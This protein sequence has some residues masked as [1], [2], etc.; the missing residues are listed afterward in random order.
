MKRSKRLRIFSSLFLGALV[1]CSLAAAAGGVRGFVLQKSDFSSKYKLSGKA[2]MS[3]AKVAK[4][5]G[6]TL[7]QLQAWGRITGYK[8]GFELNTKKAKSSDL[9]GP[10]YIVS[11]AN[12]YASVTGASAAWQASVAGVKTALPAGSKMYTPSGIGDEAFLLT[13]PE[14]SGKYTYLTCIYSWR[15]GAVTATIQTVGLKKKFRIATL[16]WLVKRQQLHITAAG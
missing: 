7:A 13:Y 16:G 1:L 5:G 15:S 8:A 9:K 14:K 6:T 11:Q 12:A 4:D 10:I 3:N 2:V